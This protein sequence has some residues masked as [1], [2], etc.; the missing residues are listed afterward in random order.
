VDSP[1][2]ILFFIFTFN[3]DDI[4]QEEGAERC[5][6]GMDSYAGVIGILWC[7]AEPDS[8]NQGGGSRSVANSSAALSD[9]ITA[10]A[11]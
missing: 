7:K 3:S 6:E 8:G 1:L 9:S 11:P 2:G 4:R 10:S 5:G